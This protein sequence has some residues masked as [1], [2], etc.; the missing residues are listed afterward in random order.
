MA[1]SF[2]CKVITPEGVL[3]EKPAVSAQF[4]VHDGLVGI[5]PDHAPMIT[6]VGRGALTLQDDGGR[7]FFVQM[8]G[9]FAEVRQNVL[10]ILADQAT[11]PSERTPEAAMRP[12]EEAREELGQAH[13]VPSRATVEEPSP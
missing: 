10:T 11:G 5:L 3:L 2:I 8:S 7:V 1:K 12:L 13:P 6:L 9:G 4:P